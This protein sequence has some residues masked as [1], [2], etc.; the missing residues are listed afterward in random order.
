MMDRIDGTTAFLESQYQIFNWSVNLKSEGLIYSKIVWTISE[1]W[2]R[3]FDW[4]WFPA[5]LKSIKYYGCFFLIQY[6]CVGVASFR[7]FW[8]TSGRN[9]SFCRTTSPDE[10]FAGGARTFPD[11]TQLWYSSIR[12]VYLLGKKISH[13]ISYSRMGN[14]LLPAVLVNP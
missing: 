6:P 2:L 9:H 1:N 10:K 8:S 14:T 13:P 7:I 5:N 4:W 3:H 11:E 12:L